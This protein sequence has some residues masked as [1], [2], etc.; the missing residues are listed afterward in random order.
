M[1]KDLSPEYRLRDELFQTMV[2]HSDFLSQANQSVSTIF[3]QRSVYEICSAT[4]TKDYS[5]RG[6][7]WLKIPWFMFGVVHAMEAGCDIRRSLKD[8]SL[9]PQGAH[10]AGF[11][12]RVWRFAISPDDLF[13]DIGKILYYTEGWNGFGY[14]SKGINS[15]YLWSGTN[16]Y[17]K[18]KFVKDG[19]FDPDAVSKQVGAA[20]LYR[21]LRDKLSKQ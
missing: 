13:Y 6:T 18:G 19:K 21:L 3:Q 10:P 4:Y 15:P 9:L 7:S 12:P 11:I 16:H 5:S 14:K 2:V 17:V 1:P 20:I 8:G